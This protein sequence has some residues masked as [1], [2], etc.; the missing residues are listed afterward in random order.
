MPVTEYLE[1]LEGVLDKDLGLQSEPDLPQGPQGDA[2]LKLR[3]GGDRSD[4]EYCANY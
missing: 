3:M 4:W 2:N 1:K